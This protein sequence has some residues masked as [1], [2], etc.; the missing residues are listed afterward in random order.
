L[1]DLLQINKM[2]NFYIFN[3]GIMTKDAMSGCE[4]RVLNWLPFFSKEAESLTIITSAQGKERFLKFGGLKIIES[5]RLSLK[6]SLGLLVNYLARAIKGCMIQ[7]YIK[8]NKEKTN[9]IYSA[10]DLIADA[11][12]AIFLKMKNRSADLIIGVH[13]LAPLPWKGFKKH[14]LKGFCWPRLSGIY[15]FISQSLVLLLVKKCASLV[16]VSNR[17]DR[18]TLIRKGFDSKKILVSYGAVNIEEA[19]TIEIK[20]KHYD[21][22]YIGR[23]HPQK[24]F[25]D[26]IDI[27][28]IIVQEIST[29]KLVVIGDD[30]N[31]K[32][33]KSIVKKR[34]LENNIN[35]R[36]FLGGSDKTKVVKSSKLAVVPSY[37]ESF[38]MVILEAMASG[39]PVVA[40]KLPVYQDIY[41]QGIKMI[42]IG[43]KSK[44]AKEI[45][46][47]LKNKTEI[48]VL[49]SQA[50]ELSKQ[51][52]WQNT[53][54]EILHH[55]SKNHS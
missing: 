26:L 18:D 37:Y 31:L 27:W 47:L 20:E 2:M 48:E 22:C 3:N 17:W 49:S 7:R 29:A 54:Q 50:R 40:Y 45:I 51:F 35:F 25:K 46:T 39:V 10:S 11:I 16:L 53:A 41:T 33:V 15:Y 30:V 13:L 52:S 36:G 44:F 23:F 42:E 12:P 8:F 6:G 1:E 5:S 21:C 24:G 14:Y 43:N 38:G 9:I 55:L 19:E 34:G 4:Q 32:Q 28:G